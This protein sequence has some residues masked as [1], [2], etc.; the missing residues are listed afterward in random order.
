LDANMLEHNLQEYFQ[1]EVRDAEPPRDWWDR[2]V[3]RLGEQKRPSFWSNLWPK[4]RLA[5]ALL[6]LALLLIAGAVYGATTLVQQMF[7]QYATTVENAGLASEFNLSQTVDGVTV[8]LE[9]AYADSNVVLLG[10][11]VRGPENRYDLDYGNSRL[12]TSDG[13]NLPM[14]MGFASVP[15]GQTILGQWPESTKAAIIAAFDASPINGTPSSLNLKLSLQFRDSPIPG[16]TTSLAGPFI[17]DFKVPFHAGE[18]INVDQTSEA[19]G[20]PITLEQVVI[21][22]W[23]TRAVLTF[24]PPYD[25]PRERP[26]SISF[27]QPA[28]GESIT[29]AFEHMAE[30]RSVEYFWENLTGQPGEWTVTVNELVFF[31][32]SSG[33]GVE[34]HPSSDTKRLSG[35]WTFHFQVP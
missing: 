32:G 34:V 26:A 4:T 7:Q 10:F 25:D 11:T 6:P 5:W 29:V 18:T 14:S 1:S 21:S 22:P 13:Q 8:K 15:G 33:Q 30:D 19:A 16:Q 20:I 27:L 2:A 9:R 12:T 24:Y 35:P 31:P 23:G 3:S 17:F 28:G